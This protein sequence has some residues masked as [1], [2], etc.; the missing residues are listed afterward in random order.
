MCFNRKRKELLESNARKRKRTLVCEQAEQVEQ[1]KRLMRR[2]PSQVAVLVRTMFPLRELP[3]S[4][5]RD[6]K[7]VLAAV[8][9][10]G[11]DLKYASKEL[12]SDRE[13]VLAAVKQNGEVLSYT[14]EKL[15]L[16]REIVL[17][18]VKQNGEAYRCLTSELRNDREIVLAAL[19]QCG[20]ALDWAAERPT[21]REVRATA[22]LVSCCPLNPAWGCCNEECACE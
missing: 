8:K 14:S 5:R 6:R 12:R 17:A 20:D 4:Y 1:L 9:K 10:E 16:D 22:G 19:K 7:I 11:E 18:A 15:H 13:I 21:I 2:L 3:L